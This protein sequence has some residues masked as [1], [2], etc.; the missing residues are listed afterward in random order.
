MPVS[1][2]IM[3]PMPKMLVSA[4]TPVSGWYAGDDIA[5]V[6]MRFG[7]SELVVSQED[8]SD[9]QKVYPGR[10]GRGFHA[11][12]E[13]GPGTPDA[14]WL[15]VM[16]DGALT[17]RERL[18]VDAESRSSAER[19]AVA[20]E[21]NRR[22]VL[23]N[24]ACS[25]CGGPLAGEAAPSG[26]PRCGTA[27]AAGTRAVSAVP[28]GSYVIPKTISTSFCGYD[29]DERGL[30]ESVA[31]QGGRVL[32]FGAGLRSEANETVISLEIADMPPIDVISVSDRLPF[33]DNTFD[34]AM[35]LH[36]LEHVPRPWVI[37]KE[38]QR[39]VKP[40]GTIL[41]TVPYVCPVH[42]FPYHFFSM[43]PR[44]L[45]G[46]F[47]DA[48]FVSH[49]LKGD[50]HPINGLRQLLGTYAGSLSHELRREFE[51]VSVGEI[52]SGELSH[53]LSSPWATGLSEAAWWEMPA[54]STLTVRKQA[55]A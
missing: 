48:E 7:A 37:A 40:G 45:R 3:L 23:S 14:A 42:G 2:A 31:A 18:V 54:H 15:E 50:S 24:L 35:S 32:D 49:T 27:F 4:Y 25:A 17:H 51:Q 36:V 9:L 34:A 53:V 19:S 8:R 55:M 20:R 26:C 39:V 30:V 46:L 29:A 43:T 47:E 5:E 1:I 11:V 16:V 13:V 41:S 52:L 44:G 6:A 21:R 38:L 28:T 10:V 22:F 33:A 12:L